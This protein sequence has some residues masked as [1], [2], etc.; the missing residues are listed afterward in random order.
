MWDK[1]ARGIKLCVHFKANY[2]NTS[3]TS[4]FNDQWLF[5]NSESV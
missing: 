3:T 4:G 5:A 1:I 2:L